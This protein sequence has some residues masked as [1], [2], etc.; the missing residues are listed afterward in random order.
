MATAVA[1]LKNL[2]IAP[3]KVRLVADMIRNKRVEEARDILA[4]T[5]K[6]SAEPLRKLLNSAVANAEYT[7]DEK[8]ERIDTD[9]M[10]ISRIVVNEGRTLQRYQPASRGRAL[11]IR[12]RS[13]HV[14]LTLTDK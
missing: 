3:R 5:L 10:V 1:K 7:A 12:K 14:E 9:S 6:G 13:S 8:H 2:S 4:F 11:R